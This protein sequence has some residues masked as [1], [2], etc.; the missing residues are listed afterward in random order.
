VK[1]GR[2][3]GDGVGYIRKGDTRIFYEEFVDSVTILGVITKGDTKQLNQM[4]KLVQELYPS[5]DINYKDL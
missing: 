3:L 4:A 1:G 5:I 2:Y